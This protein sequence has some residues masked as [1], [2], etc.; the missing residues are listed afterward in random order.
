M[1]IA[2]LLCKVTENPAYNNISSQS[3]LRLTAVVWLIKLI[4]MQHFLHFLRIN[5]LLL[6]LFCNFGTQ[7]RKT[8]NYYKNA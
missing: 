1:A 2:I 3:F 8:N 5:F 7:K 4:I 6:R